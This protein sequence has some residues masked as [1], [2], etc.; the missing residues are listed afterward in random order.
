MISAVGREPRIPRKPLPRL[1]LPECES[2]SSC[3]DDECDIT[4]SEIDDVVEPL[5][6]DSEL[7]GLLAKMQSKRFSSGSWIL[8]R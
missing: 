1:L 3:D 7:A 2:V 8:K 6:A 4:D 5:Y